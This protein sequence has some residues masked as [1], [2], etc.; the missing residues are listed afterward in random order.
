MPKASHSHTKRAA[1][2][3]EFTSSAPPST[4]GWLATMPTGLAAEPGEPGDDVLRPLRLHREELA[5]VDDRLRCTLR[6]S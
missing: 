3:A 5:V 1:L 2:S 6:M 4:I